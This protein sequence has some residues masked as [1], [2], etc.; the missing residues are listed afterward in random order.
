MHTA[1][2]RA[3]CEEAEEG[4]EEEAEEDEVEEDEEFLEV[5]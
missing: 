4:T 2:R 1:L 3:A 5:N